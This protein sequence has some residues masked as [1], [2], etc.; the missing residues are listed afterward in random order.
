VVSLLFFV[1]IQSMYITVHYFRSYLFLFFWQFYEGFQTF[2]S[3]HP[4][5]YNFLIKV[6]VVLKIFLQIIPREYTVI[7]LGL[8]KIQT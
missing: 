2:S 4:Q 1:Q 3:I 5:K 8:L 6:I 7:M